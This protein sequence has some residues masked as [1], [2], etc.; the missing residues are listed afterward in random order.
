ML[1]RGSDISGKIGNTHS[2]PVAFGE[3]DTVYVA[4]LAQEA[5]LRAQREI[6]RIQ[7]QNEEAHAKC[8]LECFE[9][10]DNE[11]NESFVQPS[12]EERR[13]WPD[14][15]GISVTLS[16]LRNEY[17]SSLVS[18]LGEEHLQAV[19]QSLEKVDNHA[20]EFFTSQE[21]HVTDIMVAV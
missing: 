16:E 4:S 3:T 18:S 17:L 1:Q 15:T 10:D 19:W 6:R 2:F 8:L 9:A 11:L 13:W 14:R 7:T 12:Q 20:P 21:G 5:K